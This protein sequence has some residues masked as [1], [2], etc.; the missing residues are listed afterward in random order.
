MTKGRVMN[1][2]YLPQTPNK[3]EAISGLMLLFEQVSKR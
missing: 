2:A 3:S 1:A